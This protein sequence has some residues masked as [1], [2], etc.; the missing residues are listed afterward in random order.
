M[1]GIAGIYNLAPGP[2]PGQDTL[3]A[4]TASFRYRGPDEEGYYTDDQVG[5]G[6]RRL[7]I[8]DIEH[9]QQPMFSD[10]RDLVSVCNGEIY[11]HL[12]LRA[13]LEARGHPFRT[14]CDVEVII[15]MYRHYGLD[16]IQ[17]FNG[18][19]GFALYDRAR[20]RLVLARDQMGIAPLFYARVGDTL[21]FASEIKG[22]LAHPDMPRAVD[23]KG[24]DHILTFPGLVSPQT[25][26]KG[27]KSLPPGHFLLVENGEMSLH[28]YWD[29]DYPAADAIDHSWDEATAAEALEER[30]SEAVRLRLQ[31]DVPVGFYLSGGLDSSLVASLIGR[32]SPATRH[33]FSI[34]FPDAAIDE[35]VHQHAMVERL[36]C[37]HHETAFDTDAISERMQAIV[38]H[39]E[40]PLKESYNTCSLALSEFVH[41]N[42]MKV[43]L[44]GEGADELLGGYVGYR[45]DQERQ[46][47]GAAPADA[48]DFLEQELQERLWG[49][50]HFFYEKH[51]YAHRETKQALYADGINQQFSAI[52]CTAAPL[53]NTAKLAALHPFHRRSYLDCKL[54]LADH[55]LSDHGDRVAYAHSVEARYPFL[56][57]D[58]I[59]L[60]TTLPPSLLLKE[61]EE[62][63]LLKRVARGHVPDSIVNRRKFAFVAP[64]SPHLLQQNTAW[65]EDMLSTE[66]IRRQ[67][68]FNPATVERLKQ[69]YRQPGFSLNTTFED[70]WL[71][72][73]LT[74][75]IL[76]DTF[77]LPDFA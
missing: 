14:R 4:M 10:G 37:T 23:P 70:D 59:T 75:G 1:C 2:P 20:R 45:L 74:F 9:G 47:Q 38:Y 24:L 43:V 68:Y 72:I 32:L 39:A 57:L 7:A 34:R 53:L 13:R 77:A 48:A 26:F 41:R 60:I 49:D 51:Y 66:R 12:D 33:S 35:G 56:D 18:Q 3:Q 36:N 42:G 17:H 46:R 30:L 25:L 16:G 63:S 8:V 21:F 31:A 6:I 28:H 52:D 11:N 58:L 27:V 76:L 5:L 54:R 64:G 67:G 62:K 40:M 15:P 61:G 71:M 29:L 73:V 55:L 44:T 22:L 69:R 19:F 65:I 50:P